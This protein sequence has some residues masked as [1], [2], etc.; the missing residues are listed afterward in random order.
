MKPKV[1]MLD[2]LYISPSGLNY[3]LPGR[4]SATRILLLHLL[5]SPVIFIFSLRNFRS[6]CITSSLI[7]DCEGNDLIHFK[8]CMYK[9]SCISHCFLLFF[10]AGCTSELRTKPETVS[11]VVTGKTL[12]IFL[13]NSSLCRIAC[14]HSVRVY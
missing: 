5:L 11:S 12:W 1:D 7:L 6:C 10:S 3:S 4:G 9:H 14:K 8:E 2:Y 13:A